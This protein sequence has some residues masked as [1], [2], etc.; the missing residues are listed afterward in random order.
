MPRT[1]IRRSH[2]ARLVTLLLL[3]FAAPEA[4]AQAGPLERGIR[5]FEQERYAEARQVLEPLAAAEPRDA[6]VA[7][8]LG[9]VHLRQENSAAAIQQLE[10]AVR[11]DP[12]VADHHLHLGNA[13][14]QRAM[15]ANVLQQARLAARAK[16]SFERAVQL[17]PRSVEA[18]FGLVRFHTM[19]PAVMGGDRRTARRHAEAIRPLNAYRGMQALAAVLRAEG[20]VEG[21]VREYR[22]GMRQ[23]PDSIGP[24]LGLIGLL[25]QANRQTEAMQTY[26]QLLALRLEERERFSAL[27]Q[28]GRLG[29]ITG[30]RLE[31]AE[32][33]LREYLQYTP[34]GNQPP[35]AVAHWRL[36][37]VLEKQGRP[38][39]ARAQYQAAQARDPAHRESRDALRRLAA[40]RG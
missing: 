33:A 17:D 20:D 2:T 32:S 30:H 35:L 6:R 11:L 22:D 12:D 29:A 8:W 18:H 34:S 36:G 23:Y 7:Y 14:G 5:L 1:K 28:V 24:Y 26:E 39:E 9:R 15:N 37:M 10:R 40:G 13:Y 31:R 21:A 16:G 3:S 25:E 27:Y 4:D 38:D 19:A